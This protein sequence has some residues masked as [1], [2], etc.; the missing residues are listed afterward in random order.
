QVGM[1]QEAAL[2]EATSCPGALRRASP[3]AVTVAACE[4]ASNRRRSYAFCAVYASCRPGVGIQ[5]KT[6]KSAAHNRLATT[7]LD[8]RRLLGPTSSTSHAIRPA[9]IRLADSNPAAGDEHFCARQG[10]AA[11]LSDLAPPGIAG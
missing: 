7:I 3:L 5:N 8:Y 11:E 2:P 1:P 10:R 4:P 6:A 9:C